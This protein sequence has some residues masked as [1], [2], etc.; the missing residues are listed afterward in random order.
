MF[1]LEIITVIVVLIV[2]GCFGVAAHKAEKVLNQRRK[3]LR[4][5]RNSSK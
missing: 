4:D 5:A 3:E 2:F 1:G